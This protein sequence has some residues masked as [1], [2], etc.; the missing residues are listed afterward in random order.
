MKNYL[1]KYISF[2][3]NKQDHTNSLLLIKLNIE[4]GGMLK[5]DFCPLKK[6]VNCKKDMDH[7]S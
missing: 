1:F 3:V 2:I 6:A 5:P 4:G 7:F